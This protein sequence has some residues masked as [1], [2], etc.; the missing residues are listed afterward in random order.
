LAFC[1]NGAAERLRN[2]RDE[3]RPVHSEECGEHGEVDA[4][5][6]FSACDLQPEPRAGGAKATPHIVCAWH[7]PDYRAWACKPIA[8]PGADPNCEPDLGVDIARLLARALG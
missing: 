3:R 5:E 4:V 1:G 6:A 7:T 2:G 8:S